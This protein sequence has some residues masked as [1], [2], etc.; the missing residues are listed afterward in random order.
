MLRRM[1][2]EVAVFV[3]RA[4]LDRQVLAPQRQERSLEARGAVD[5]HELWSFQ[6]A[7]IEVVKEVAPGSRALPAH[8]PDGQQYLLP[9]A[10]YADCG[11]H[12]DVGGFPVQPGLDHG[13]IEE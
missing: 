12:R 13:A 9:V 10:A 3:N 6:A 11:K 8:I 4:A 7:R 2:Q 5:D 1:G